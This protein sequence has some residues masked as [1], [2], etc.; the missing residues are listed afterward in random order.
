MIMS[1]SQP[2]L[3]AP[4]A[5][6]SAREKGDLLLE[7]VRGGRSLER[8]RGVPLDFSGADLLGAQLPQANP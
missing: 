3:P 7:H 5:T 8:A 1:G 6:M 4:T 2:P